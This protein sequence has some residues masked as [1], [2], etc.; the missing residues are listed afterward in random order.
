MRLGS[1]IH[2][3]RFYEAEILFSNQMFVSRFAYLLFQDIVESADFQNAEKITVYSYALYSELLVVELITM[4]QKKYSK[5]SFDYAILERE[6]EHREFLHSDRMRY[7]LDFQ[8]VQERK[9]HFEDRKIIC[10]VPVNSTLKTHEKLISLLKE[11]N[12][13]KVAKNVILNYALILVGS[14]KENK[15]WTIDSRKKTFSRVELNIQPMPKYFVLVKVDY[16]E[17]LGCKMCFPENPLNEK[18]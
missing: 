7:S 6:A 15:Y 4:L 14:E 17:A 3:S 11:D 13:E 2:I 12:G 18:Q 10:I 16:Q 9:K 1:T 8:N 5:K